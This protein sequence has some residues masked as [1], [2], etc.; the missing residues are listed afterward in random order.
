MLDAA[1]LLERHINARGGLKAI[2]Q[3]QTL[4]QRGTVTY[5]DGA[6]ATIEGWR[7]RPNKL[8]LHYIWPNEEY[9]EGWDGT[10]SWSFRPSQHPV[11]IQT[12][13]KAA[14]NVRFGAEFD[15]PLV[16][17]YMK[18]REIES[19]GA[20]VVAGLPVYGLRTDW[21]FGASIIF[22]LHK[23]SYM[24]AAHETIMHGV[25]TPSARTMYTDYCPVMGVMIPHYTVQ[26]SSDG[27]YNETY[28]W[29]T[30]EANVPLDDAF[31]SMPTAIMPSAT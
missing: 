3:L 7:K 16:Q 18:T 11:P 12:I 15:S 2:Q 30:F 6:V 28:S 1:T 13:G 19:L 21:Q 29:R 10:H 31:F 26:V 22:Y 5:R 25:D 24:V 20:C 23:D 17:A 14:E 9:T 4:Y 27:S 8:R